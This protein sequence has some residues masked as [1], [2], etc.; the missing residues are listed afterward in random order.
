MTLQWQGKPHIIDAWNVLKD[1]DN[2]T[3]HAVW[4][5]LLGANGEPRDYCFAPG[6]LT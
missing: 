1:S 5:Y 4:W 3:G 2:P 6:P